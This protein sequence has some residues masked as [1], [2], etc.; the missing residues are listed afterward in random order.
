MYENWVEIGKEECIALVKEK[1]I[2]DFISSK[3]DDKEEKENSLESLNEMALTQTKERAELFV[4]NT[5]DERKKL[6]NEL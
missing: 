3:N 4:G 1:S 2:L 6:K 5:S